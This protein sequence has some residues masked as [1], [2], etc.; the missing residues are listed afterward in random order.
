MFFF[1]AIQNKLILNISLWFE[2]AYLLY[3]FTLPL[4]ERALLSD[5]STR[6]QIAEITAPLEV[7]V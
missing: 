5:R 6:W 4:Q 1:K 7:K 2:K 3:K